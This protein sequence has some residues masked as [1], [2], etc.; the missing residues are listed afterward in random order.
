MAFCDIKYITVAFCSTGCFFALQK[1]LGASPT[2]KCRIKRELAD[3]FRLRNTG[4]FFL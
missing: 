1:L 2:M 3:I 4:L